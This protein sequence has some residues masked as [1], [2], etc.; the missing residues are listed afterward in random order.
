M[1]INEMAKN[2]ASHGG[3]GLAAPI[4]AEMLHA[5]EARLGAGPTLEKTP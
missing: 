4:L 3:L 2:I 1:L 5:Q